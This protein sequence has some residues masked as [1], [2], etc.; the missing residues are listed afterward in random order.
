MRRVIRV[1]VVFHEGA[2]RLPPWGLEYSPNIMVDG[3]C[4]PGMRF[5]WL[6][7]SPFGSQ[8][9]CDVELMYEDMGQCYAKFVPGVRFDVAEGSKIVGEGVVLD[10]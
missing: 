6:P 8:I 4:F 9:V 5:A 3:R 7:Q 2:R 10:V 1:K